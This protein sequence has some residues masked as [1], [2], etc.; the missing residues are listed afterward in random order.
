MRQDSPTSKSVAFRIIKQ[1]ILCM[2]WP[3]VVSQLTMIGCH[4]FQ[5][6]YYACHNGGPWKTRHPQ[7]YS[8]PRRCFNN[9]R[10]ND[11]RGAIEIQTPIVLPSHGKEECDCKQHASLTGNKG[12][13]NFGTPSHVAF[14]EIDE[15]HCRGQPKYG[16]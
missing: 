1:V 3:L 10:A 16:L 6:R 12:G 4:C 8:E 14:I 11:T 5:S 13:S 2:G 15:S 9:L 7:Y